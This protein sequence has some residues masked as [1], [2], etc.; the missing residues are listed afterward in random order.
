MHISRNLNSYW[1]TLFMTLYNIVFPIKK[2]FYLFEMLSPKL[3]LY[4]VFK[5]GG[6]KFLTPN[7]NY[8]LTVSSL[9]EL[10]DSSFTPIAYVIASSVNHLLGWDLKFPRTLVLNYLHVYTVWEIYRYS[11][12]I[13]TSCRQPMYNISAFCSVWYKLLLNKFCHSSLAHTPLRQWEANSIRQL[14]TTML[15]N[16][17]DHIA[18]SCSLGTLI[19]H[20]SKDRKVMVI[21]ITVDLLSMIY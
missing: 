4:L 18:S 12:C 13:Q 10:H 2:F 3:L 6:C 21:H 15:Y 1:G 7:I 17:N 8:C 9:M 14:G 19:Q 11:L 5:F 16:C 20:D